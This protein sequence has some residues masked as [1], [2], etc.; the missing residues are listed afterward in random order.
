MFSVSYILGVFRDRV[1]VENVE[2]MSSGILKIPSLFYVAFASI[3]WLIL[4]QKYSKMGKIL[5]CTNVGYF[6]AIVSIIVNA[7]DIC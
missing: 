1:V 7:H 3:L 4:K 6:N 5:N 2:L